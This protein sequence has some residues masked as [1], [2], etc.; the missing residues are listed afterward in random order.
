MRKSYNMCVK[1]KWAKWNKTISLKFERLVLLGSSAEELSEKERE[2]VIYTNRIIYSLIVFQ[3]LLVFITLMF[4]QN[5]L[6][7]ATEILVPFF[8]LFGQSLKW[9]GKI[10]LS[11]TVLI[12]V[13]VL[14]LVA[15]DKIY[16]LSAREEGG[17]FLY[18]FLILFVINMTLRHSEYP[19]FKKLLVYAYPFAGMTLCF[20]S[21]SVSDNFTDIFHLQLNS[22]F[23]FNVL[24]VFSM[25]T[26]LLRLQLSLNNKLTRKIRAKQ[27]KILRII[28]KNNLYAINA[29]IVAEEKEKKRFSQELHDSVGQL[30]AT[31]KANLDL[32]TIEQ[33]NSDD[34]RET[35][36][37]CMHLVKLAMSEVR[38]ISHN[39]MPAILVD[40]G[41]YDAVQEIC[42]NTR[43]RNGTRITFYSE[44]NIKSE[45]VP[46]YELS[47][48]LYRIVQES[49][50]NI[51]RHSG[52]DEA[53]VRMVSHFE[54]YVL[55]ISDN[56]RG[57]DEKAQK[58]NGL[59]NIKKRV[60]AIGAWVS[61]ESRP[62]RGTSIS[63]IIARK[64]L[65][66]EYEFSHGF[67]QN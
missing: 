40:F 6:L 67:N 26:F 66:K 24:C 15:L 2:Y 5:L 8:T 18:F 14:S 29:G 64:Q 38:N 59:E 27:K 28:E 31:T 44:K 57:F 50:S 22:M 10:Y 21:F 43:L 63:V 11:T 12:I 36:T 25:L 4:S 62:E 1:E 58:G 3:A 52:A 49:I 17:F 53:S 56:G 20:V 41:F 46:C 32:L 65:F 51:L 45:F 61:I 48:H 37:N 54:S 35:I 30:L 19:V 55:S 33:N 39:L 34:T 23:F 60:L 42:K 13:S 16:F 7:I 47:L 9:L